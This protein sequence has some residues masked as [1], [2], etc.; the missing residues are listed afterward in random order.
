VNDQIEK[1]NPPTTD[2]NSY[3]AEI[4]LLFMEGYSSVQMSDLLGPEPVDVKRLR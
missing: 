2:K 1:E 3:V 4:E